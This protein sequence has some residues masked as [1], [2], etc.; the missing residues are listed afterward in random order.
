V[1]NIKKCFKILTEVPK[2]YSPFILL[3]PAWFDIGGTSVMYV[4]L[5]LTSA[6]SFQ[7]LRGSILIFVG[8]MSIIFLKRKLEWFRWLGMFIIMCGLVTVGVSD[9]LQV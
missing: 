4:A 1:P 9:F 6:S 8:I 3:P 5:T 7:M 2:S